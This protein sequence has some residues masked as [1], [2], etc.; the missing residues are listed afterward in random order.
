[1]R[2][3]S[4]EGVKVV[5]RDNRGSLGKESRLFDDELKDVGSSELET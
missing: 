5:G 4:K 1:M 2:M 3:S